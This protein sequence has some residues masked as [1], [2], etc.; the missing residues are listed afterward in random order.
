MIGSLAK[1]VQSTLSEPL[2]SKEPELIKA[3]VGSERINLPNFVVIYGNPGSGKT[4]F[5]RELS[6][7]SRFTYLGSDSIFSSHVAPHIPEWELFLA[8][9]GQPNEHFNVSQY[10]DSNFYDY[11]LFISCLKDELR[12]KL[13]QFPR[14]HTVLLDGYVFKNHTQVVKDLSL[15]SERVLALHAS[16]INGRHMIEKFDVTYYYYDEILK[17]IRDNFSA[18]CAGTTVPKSHYQS[19][20]SL[21]LSGLGTHKSDSNTE[22]KYSASHLDKVLQPSDRVVDIGCNSGYFCFRVAEKTNGP[23]AGVD[24][25]RNP[26]EIASH[27]NNSIFLRDSI[28]F[29]K[30][31]ALEF[32]AD[33][34]N[35]FEIVHCASTYHYFRERQIAFLREAYR[36][37]SSSGVLVLEVELANTETKAEIIKRAR[38]VDSTPCAFP[39]RAMFL[40]Q[41]AGLFDIEDEFES[42]FQK[43]SFYSRVY[44]HLRPIRQNVKFVLDKAHGNRISGWA[45]HPRFPQQV[46]K[47]LIRISHENEFKEFTVLANLHRPDLLSKQI[48]LTGNCGFAL[49][50]PENDSLFPGDIVTVFNMGDGAKKIDKKALLATANVQ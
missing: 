26:L 38:G 5:A 16:I 6:K 27:I 14:T 23:V 34:P 12:R 32:L 7:L 49:F 9:R 10:V 39:N 29:F 37:L 46:V 42:V 48:H 40:Q 33:S 31:E 36:A 35:S 44:F 24:F 25:S 8:Y 30:A 11:S 20:K 22:E 18:S 21:G 50:L 19:F 47:L 3:G 2:I 41:I 17:Y 1:I 13:Q 28:T 43:G 4:S 15:P 45:M